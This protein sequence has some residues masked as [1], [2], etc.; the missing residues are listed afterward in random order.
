MVTVVA[1]VEVERSIEAVYAYVADLRN[2]MYWWRGVVT[3]ERL[4]GDGG[5]GTEYFQDT[6][7]L[8][9]RFPARLQVLE[10]DP[11]DRM[12]YRSLESKTPFTATYSLVAL[13]PRRTRFTMTAEAEATGALKL[14]G[15]LFSPILGM[16]ARRYFGTLRTAVP[17]G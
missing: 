1:S 5:P 10:A 8:G 16:L 17:Q 4:S 11:P 6:K 14:L 13:A 12:V 2:D 7:L 15:P 9:L 3:A